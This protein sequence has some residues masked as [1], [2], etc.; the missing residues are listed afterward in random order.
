MGYFIGVVMGTAAK[1]REA[2]FILDGARHGVVP[3]KK[4][5]D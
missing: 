1:G 2:S 3:E 5:I 4:E